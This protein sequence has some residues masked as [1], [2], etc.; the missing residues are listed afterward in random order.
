[1][2]RRTERLEY[3]P[4]NYQS[5]QLSINS[6]ISQSIIT[7]SSSVTMDN[8]IVAQEHWW[9]KMTDVVC[10]TFKVSCRATQCDTK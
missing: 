8:I 3:D 9:A 6:D 2:D 5:S 10:L 1:M 7:T 4:I